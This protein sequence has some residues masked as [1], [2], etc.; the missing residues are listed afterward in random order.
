MDGYLHRRASGKTLRAARGNIAADRCAIARRPGHPELV[1]ETIGRANRNLCLSPT[2]NICTGPDPR[3][4]NFRDNLGYILKYSRKLNLAE[5]TPRGE[6]SS[7]TYCLAQTPSQGAE[8]LVYAPAGGTF[9]VDLSAMASSRTLA[10]ECFNPSTG[11]TTTGDSVVAGSSSSF[12]PPFSGDAVLYLVDSAGHNPA[13]GKLRRSVT[14][15][16]L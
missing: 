12:T 14:L 7:T 1:G 16:R 10:V 9:T 6:L 8:Y 3:W 4:D 11:T 5:V 2:N 15:P 13:R